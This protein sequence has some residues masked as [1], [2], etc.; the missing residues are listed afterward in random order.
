MTQ[1][2][3]VKFQKNLVNRDSRR[4][5]RCSPAQTDTILRICHF[6]MF[7]ELQPK[8]R[9]GSLCSHFFPIMPGYTSTPNATRKVYCSIL[10]SKEPRK[11]GSFDPRILFL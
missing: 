1:D 6:R 4:S 2:R 5:L 8:K 11:M 10:G 3:E 7:S 9:K